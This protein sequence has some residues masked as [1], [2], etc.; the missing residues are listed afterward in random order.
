MYKFFLFVANSLLQKIASHS[1]DSGLVKILVLLM[2]VFKCNMLHRFS[3]NEDNR[4][5]V[6]NM[7][8]NLAITNYMSYQ[9][10][11]TTLPISYRPTIKAVLDQV[12]INAV[13]KFSPPLTEW[14]FAVPLVHFVT[15][16]CKPNQRLEG[17][18]WDFDE[19]SD[20]MARLTC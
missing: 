17:I 20:Q 15:E 12:I 4:F 5:I 1:A 3:S 16:K 2:I 13:N 6:K 19:K 7:L 8:K 10:V 18:G 11:I 9:I 14:I